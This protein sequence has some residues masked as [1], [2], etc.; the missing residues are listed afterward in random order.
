MNLSQ[1]VVG[2]SGFFIIFGAW[3]F[4]FTE[5]LQLGQVVALGMYLSMITNPFRRIAEIYRTLMN[6]SVSAQRLGD[7]LSN[8]NI[9]TERRHRLN[10]RIEKVECHNLNYSYGEKEDCLRGVDFSVCRGET[11]AIVGH[12][13]AGKSTLLRILAGLEDSYSGS[14]KVNGI[15]IKHIMAGSYFTQIAIV[16]QESFFFADTLVGNLSFSGS[17]VSI[18]KI[19]SYA[20]ILGI[21]DIIADLKDVEA[22]KFGSEGRGFSVGQFQKLSTLRA[23]LKKASLILLDEITSSIDIES[24]KKLLRGVAELKH[25]ECITFLV[26][27]DVSIIDEKTVDR[28]IIMDKGRVVKICTPTE[29]FAVG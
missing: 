16:P 23:M 1:I 4:V 8:E 24:Q 20:Q 27:H 10:G 29:F 18:C 14:I 25:P 6:G 5:R 9:Q 2:G 11:T 21:G 7:I 26:T 19:H 22:I 17:Q 3:Y 13:G 12:S 28:V 15:E